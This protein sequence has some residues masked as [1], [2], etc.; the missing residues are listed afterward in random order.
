[1]DTLALSHTMHHSVISEPLEL[2]GGELPLQP[3]VER[4][5]HEEIGQHG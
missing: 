5:I 2:Y 3:P 1:M 4:I